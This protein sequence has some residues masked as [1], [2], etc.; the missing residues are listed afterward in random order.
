[1]SEALTL[2]A[3]RCLF[4]AIPEKKIKSLMIEFAIFSS[5]N[6]LQ[7]KNE[8]ALVCNEWCQMSRSDS[9]VLQLLLLGFKVKEVILKSWSCSE[10]ILVKAWSAL[11]QQKFDLVND[12]YSYEFK[13]VW[14]DE[15]A[16]NIRSASQTHLQEFMNW[17]ENLEAPFRALIRSADF[18]K[19]NLNPQECFEIL[20][21]LP[22]LTCL[23]YDARGYAIPIE[24]EHVNAFFSH[25]PKL[26]ELSLASI[27]L[28]GKGF[29][30]IFSICL[31]LRA[32][33][34]IDS[35]ET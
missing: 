27:N 19:K 17:L 2:S 13:M 34:I 7:Q 11:F 5:Q 10:P 1:M 23:T 20:K 26:E 6:P 14:D 9:V 31:S 29:S 3:N 24:D 4:D 18:S 33:F 8:L 22:E 32:I 28:S 15:E 21:K 30:E 25:C 35:A 12:D 16:E